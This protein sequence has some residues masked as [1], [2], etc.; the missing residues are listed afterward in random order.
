MNQKNFL[1]QGMFVLL[2]TI[3]TKYT[4]AFPRGCKPIG[5]YSYQNHIIFNDTGLQSYFLIENNS[6]QKIQLQRIETHG[7]YISP[8]L[9]VKLSP[10]NF[11]AFASNI[12]NF[13]FLC[14]SLDENNT[15]I[16]I[17]KCAN[18]L[19]VC[20]FPKVKFAN[21]NLGNYWVSYNKSQSE[22]INESVHKGIYLKW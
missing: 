15:A 13:H 18:V 19:S 22:V 1:I 8:A 16:D 2:L 14:V 20:Q 10:K 9:A 7:T 12:A 21:T 6:T 17:L 3:T 5:Y 11:A 4:H